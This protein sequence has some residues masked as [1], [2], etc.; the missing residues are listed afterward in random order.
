MNRQEITIVV[1]LFLLL[2]GWSVFFRKQQPPPAEAPTGEQQVAP[3]EPA[4]D[5]PSPAPA[6][7][8][9][10]IAAAPPTAVVEPS[11][12]EVTEPT[13][14]LPPEERVSLSSKQATVVL[15]S[16]SGSIVSAELVE[17]RATLEKDSDP[18]VLDFSEFPALHLQGING[19]GTNV[20]YDLEVEGDTA[21]AR[22]RLPSGVGFER[23]IRFTNGYMLAI[24]DTFSNP[25]TQSVVL[26]SAS[27]GV[28]P[29]HTIQT[30]AKTRGIAYLG[31]D[32]LAAEGGSRVVHWGKKFNGFFGGKSS[33]FSCARPDMRSAPML[34]TRRIE[35]PIDWVAAKNKYFVQIL[36]FDEPADD[37]EIRVMRDAAASNRV[38]LAS[39][40][41]RLLLPDKTIAP[42][43]TLTRQVSY[44]VGPKKY[45]ILK[46]LGK[47]KGEVMQFGWW[48]WFRWLCRTL[49]WTLNAL[50]AVIPSYGVAIIVVTII[51]RILFWP[52]THKSTESMKKMQKIQPLVTEIR[53]K[54]K[55]KPQKMNQEVM[56]LYKEH[57]VNPMAGCLP[58]VVQI[59]VFIALFIVLRSAVEL[60]FAEFLWIRDLSEPEGLLAGTIP[61]VGSLNILPLFMTL[62]TVL[63]QRLTPTAGDPQQQK[64]M[65]IMPVVFLFLFYNMASALV[66]YWSV[67]QCLAV[68]QLVFQRRRKAVKE[69]VIPAPAP[70]KAEIARPAPHKK[71]RKRR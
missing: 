17:Y 38:A 50:N 71:R 26:A 47:Y 10:A 43:G 2:I 66:L 34:V 48:D 45:S 44:Y 58:M 13:V 52:I 33:P 41:A 60:R 68:V 57:K 63:Q 35:T 25:G 51:V 65:M 37:C 5:V 14:P 28:G 56:A 15:S 9:P 16:H 39:T 7:A 40:S 21:F 64:M 49:L 4:P 19:L 22:R 29:M 23:A 6:E 62:T 61:I 67:S 36:A 31:L 18:L 3:A 12:P 46:D 69:E 20:H 55:D 53:E 59:P 32:S 1:L 54:Y 11:D 27:L 42:G 8:T 30:K 24:T 70:K